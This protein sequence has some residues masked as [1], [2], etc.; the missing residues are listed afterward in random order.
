MVFIFS[1]LAYF[2]SYP[3]KE[4]IYS[5]KI[6][7]VAL[8]I[9]FVYDSILYLSPSTITVSGIEA[10]VKTKKSFLGY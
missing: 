10:T 4:K 7:V 6:L 2:I 9:L 8:M 1:I 3:S 5:N